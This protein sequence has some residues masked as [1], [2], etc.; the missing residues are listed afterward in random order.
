MDKDESI[1]ISSNYTRK[2]KRWKAGDKHSVIIAGGNGRGN[3]SNQLNCP[4]RLTFDRQE[5]LLY[6]AD[7]LD[8]PVEKFSIQSK[9]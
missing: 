7:L 9:L 5:N 6:V 4:M 8:Y 2:V 1:Y 3:Q